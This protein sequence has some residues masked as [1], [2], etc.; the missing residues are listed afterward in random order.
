VKQL[1][2][3]GKLGIKGLLQCLWEVPDPVLA[4]KAFARGIDMVETFAVDRYL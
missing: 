2:K 4:E 1:P 3:S